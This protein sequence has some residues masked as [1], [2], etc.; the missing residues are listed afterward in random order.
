MLKGLL[1]ILDMFITN[2]AVRYNE[3]MFS[4]VMFVIANILLN[5]EFMSD[6]GI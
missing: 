6:S 3:I 5:M 2:A 1:A 4:S